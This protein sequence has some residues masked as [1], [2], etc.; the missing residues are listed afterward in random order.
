MIRQSIY[1]IVFSAYQMLEQQSVEEKSQME[2][3]TKAANFLQ[4]KAHE[5][6]THIAKLKVRGWSCVY[7]LLFIFRLCE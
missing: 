3:R 4:T 1:L 2:K 6:G 5:Y 7:L